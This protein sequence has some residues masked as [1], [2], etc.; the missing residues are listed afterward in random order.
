LASDEI[1]V[2]IGH[3]HRLIGEGLRRLIGSMRG[4]R[5]VDLVEDAR[6]I[7]PRMQADVFLLDVHLPNLS[8]TLARWGPA[9]HERAV[10][11][12]LP[13]PSL[14]VIGPAFGAIRGYVAPD[15]PPEELRRGLSRLAHNER[16]L[17]RSL[18]A[19]PLIPL[20]A[21]QKEIAALVALGF[22]SKEIGRTLGIS[23]RTVEGHRAELMRK[24]QARNAANL[25]S[26]AG[27]RG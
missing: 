8:R 2:V 16:Y 5:V 27:H 15:D 11:L 6:S 13:E 20:S 17:S 19:I 24:L 21:R 9:V 26:I 1:S 14:D 12:L 7:G 10:A 4:V 25:G 3:R 18:T 22:S 23:T